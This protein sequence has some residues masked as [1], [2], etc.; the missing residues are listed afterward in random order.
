MTNNMAVNES[1][2]IETIVFIALMLALSGFMA[3]CT[4]KIGIDYTGRTGVDNRTATVLTSSQPRVV[5]VSK[6]S[7]VRGED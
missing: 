1:N 4:F 6:T 2:L 5:T 7:H 3:G